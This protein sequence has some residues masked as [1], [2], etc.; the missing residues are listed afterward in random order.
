MP[1]LPKGIYRRGRSFYC[2]LFE[3]GRE[4]RRSLGKD[5][6][7]A[8]RKLRAMRR[9][10]REM[11]L[12][13]TLVKD[14]VARWLDTAIRNGRNDKGVRDATTRAKKYLI[15]HLG[16]LLLERVGENDLREFR[17][18]LERAGGS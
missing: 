13:R 15:P 2:R 8:C 5:Y 1:K 16:E 7:A 3:G 10:R 9:E 6:E 12:G 11:P 17:T 18:R 4:V 14:V